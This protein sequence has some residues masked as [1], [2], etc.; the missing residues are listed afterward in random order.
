MTEGQQPLKGIKVV[1]MSQGIA[2]PTACQA[3]L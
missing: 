1:D 2:G 3:S